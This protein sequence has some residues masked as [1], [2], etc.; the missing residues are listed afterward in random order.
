MAATMATRGHPDKSDGAIHPEP[1][2]LLFATGRLGDRRRAVTTEDRVFPLARHVWRYQDEMPDEQ[3][4]SLFA[5]LA[6]LWPK[7]SGRERVQEE[8]AI[9]AAWLL[10]VGVLP[11]ELPG[12]LGRKGDTLRRYGTI[13]RAAR[14]L[15]APQVNPPRLPRVYAPG[16][17]E[18]DP[19]AAFDLSDDSPRTPGVVNLLTG[20]V[21]RD[22][23][24]YAA[25]VTGVP[26]ERV[27][28][29]ERNPPTPTRPGQPLR[30]ASLEQ[31]YTVLAEANAVRA[32]RGPYRLTD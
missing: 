17:Y 24:I 28:E 6:E 15:N 9:V 10:K 21:E 22:P 16:E 32:L 13:D 26:V 11:D 4:D 12:L 25:L 1:E 3:R 14:L 18:D 30:A 20:I 29:L 31:I 5:A 19:F 27:R 7:P 23:P 2:E 8:L